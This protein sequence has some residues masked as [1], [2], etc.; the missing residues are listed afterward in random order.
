MVEVAEELPKEHQAAPT[1]VEVA[2]ILHMVLLDLE[3][4]GQ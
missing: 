1:V 3:P 4:S 2:G